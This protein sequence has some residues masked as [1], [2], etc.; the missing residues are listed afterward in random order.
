[1][2]AFGYSKAL[3]PLWNTLPVSCDIFCKNGLGVLIVVNGA[4]QR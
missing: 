4:S 1:M 3:Y 2:L